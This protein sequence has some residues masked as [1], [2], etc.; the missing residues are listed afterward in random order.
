MDRIAVVGDVHGDVVRLRAMLRSLETFAGRII[1]VGDYVGGGPDSAEVLEILANLDERQPDRFEFLC[2]NHD[3]AFLGYIDQGAFAPF[4][5]ADGLATLASYLPL[6]T[7]DVHTALLGA[8]PAHHRAFLAN[9]AS[10]WESDAC[11]VSHTGFD[12][13]RPLVRDVTTL[14]SA[15]GWPVFDAASYP[16]SLVVCGHYVQRHGPHDS[17]HLICVDTGCGIVP[18]G[19][20]SAVLLPERRFVTI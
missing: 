20:L 8:V 19:G 11:L 2:G 4:V 15:T 12:P 10:C 13:A 14:A 1:F 6:V 16:R 7:G 3:V 18:N 17:E 5:A 9:L